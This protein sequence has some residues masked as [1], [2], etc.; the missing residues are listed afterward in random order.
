MA[1][2]KVGDLAPT[3]TPVRAAV[4]SLK[5]RRP[6]MGYPQDDESFAEASGRVI[7]IVHPPGSW[8]R[9]KQADSDHEE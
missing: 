4:R 5:D 3:D 2:L 9:S 7:I 1:I 8:F 6:A